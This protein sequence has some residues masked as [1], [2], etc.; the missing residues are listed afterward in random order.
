MEQQ[1]ADIPF[2][3]FTS[4]LK[5]ATI[6]INEQLNYLHPNLGNVYDV[7]IF[8]NGSSSNQDIGRVD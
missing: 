2:E 1:T 6:E 4:G 7:Y 8:A 5:S 3:F